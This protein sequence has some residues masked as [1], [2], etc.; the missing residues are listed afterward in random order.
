MKYAFLLILVFKLPYAFES[1]SIPDPFDIIAKPEYD[2]YE[3]RNPQIDRA[4]DFT[5]YNEVTKSKTGCA[6]WFDPLEL[7][8]SAGDCACCKGGKKGGVQ[9]GYPMHN[10]CQRKVDDGE[11]QQGCAG[12][13]LGFFDYF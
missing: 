13:F 4:I 11:E 9:C 10:Y 6:C 1:A 5:S 8:T 7:F 2:I 12:I 3:L